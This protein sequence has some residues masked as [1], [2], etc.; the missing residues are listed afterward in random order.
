MTTRF[1]PWFFLATVAVAS[2][3]SV[4]CHLL[5]TDL[6]VSEDGTPLRCRADTCNGRG[7]CDHSSGVAVCTCDAPY[8]G[9]YCD[10]CMAGLKA[11]ADTCTCCA[12][13]Q[14]PGFDD[15]SHWTVNG[16]AR[17]EGGSGRLPPDAACTGGTLLQRVSIPPES[18]TGPLMVALT[19]RATNITGATL[20]VG[21]DGKWTDLGAVPTGGFEPR[22]M[23]L[24]TGFAG[25][26]IDLEIAPFITG[27]CG[28]FQAGTIE[29]DHVD[30]VP[31]TTEECPPGGLVPNG[32]FEDGDDGWTGSSGEWV[33]GAEGGR[34][35][36][37]V[38][39]LTGTTGALEGLVYIPPGE[40]AEAPAIQ[41]WHHAPST[42]VLSVRVGNQHFG[43]WHAQ[44][45]WTEGRACLPPWLAGT[46][47]PIFFEVGYVGQ[48]AG[49]G[50]FTALLDD[51]AVVSD[52]RC[53]WSS[54]FIGGD[55]EPLGEP[56]LSRSM[57]S[58][59]GWASYN[60]APPPVRNTM[61]AGYFAD[62]PVGTCLEYCYAWGCYYSA[63]EYY[64]LYGIGRVPAPST[65]GGPALVYSYRRAGTPT[66][67][68]TYFYGPGFGE[69]LA[70]S[71]E[72]Q[73]MVH[74]L[75][76]GYAGRMTW[77]AIEHWLNS[78]D[79]HNACWTY[80]PTGELLFPLQ[81]KDMEL[82]TDPSCD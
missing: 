53:D 16:A 66:D 34:D 19:V 47:A 79:A 39:R 75:P 20:G 36:G 60:T 12:I 51:V 54:G 28:G 74:C 69:Q 8:G 27:L 61:E 57:T 78:E 44:G 21:L 45:E 63:L 9:Q 17:I 62:L 15:D 58:R 24:G 38:A 41:L 67:T 50:S 18:Y 31:A 23:C 37:L 43:A 68:G 55:F 29:I 76:S 81:L 32:D 13:V 11:E 3:A 71:D 25:R 35:G 1:L 33:I 48:H 82:V 26:E 2:A 56:T 65:T 22:T 4:G 77:F 10:G 46:W 6:E 14:N 70:A 49:T 30:I 42:V 40:G 59:M 52:A 80:G 5:L 73:P 72:W 7:T 64:Y